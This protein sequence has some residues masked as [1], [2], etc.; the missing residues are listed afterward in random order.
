[1]KEPKKQKPKNQKPKKQKQPREKAVKHTRVNESLLAPLERPVLQWFTVRMPA[2]VNP[3]ML[4]GL[5]FLGSVLI[6]A[7]YALT[8]IDVRFMW[9]SSFG[10]LV[11]WFGDSL[12]GTL[13]RYRKIERPRYGYFIDH[14]VDTATEA[15]VFIGMG[16]SPFIDLRLALFALIGY[17]MLS[18]YVFLVTYVSGEF[19]I[20]FAKL[21]P[22]EIRGIGILANT[23]M[24]VLGVSKISTPLGAFTFFD[25]VL[26]LISVVFYVAFV[27]IVLNK[28]RQ[29]S[30]EDTLARSI[31]E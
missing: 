14:V 31:K 17:F 5:G 30:R 22:T 3:D 7:G 20:S 1:M 18:I 26:I 15:L 11:N 9:L 19:R 23:G 2:W 24:L 4:T 6:F 25:M 29:L 8:S 27:I 13:A 16:L 21:S 12:D 10:L 28:A